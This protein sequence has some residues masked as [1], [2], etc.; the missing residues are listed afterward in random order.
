MNEHDFKKLI[1]RYLGGQCTTEEKQLVENW[2]DFLEKQ[3]GR[4]EQWN[5]QEQQK[6]GIEM[7]V[8]LQKQI[9]AGKQS[10]PRRLVIGAGW[11]IAASILLV[12]GLVYG[13]NQFA[14][15]RDSSTLAHHQRTSNST[16]GVNKQILP[17]GTLVWLKGKSQLTFPAT[18]T[19]QLREVNLAGEALFEVA[20]DA[21]HPFVIHCGSLRTR[22]VGTS[23]HM[24]STPDQQQIEVVVFTGKVSLSLE[25]DRKETLLLPHQ[26]ALYRADR[27]SITTAVEEG[28]EGYLTG[29][30][31]DMRFEDT[32]LQAV[33]QRVE[34]KFDIRI[35]LAA[36]GGHSCL[37]NA[38]LTDQSLEV[39]LSLIS[40]ALGGNYQ[41]RG[42]NIRLEIPGCS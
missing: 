6:P 5:G 9:H 41:I 1:D 16:N 20:K 11:R 42:S 28:V 18:F 35:E 10:S 13:V 39:T 26:K 3:P 29:T 22:V 33:V 25:S 17:D 12:M 38:D 19:G 15:R 4:F 32:P 34:Q 8:H 14:L 40:Q 36:L 23:F 7:L 37:V 21:S 2:L 27:Q 30:Q 31:Y 24:R